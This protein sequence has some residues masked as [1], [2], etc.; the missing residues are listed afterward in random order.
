VASWVL[1]GGNRCTCGFS[2]AYDAVFSFEGCK[3]WVIDANAIGTG[4]RE[5][6]MAPNEWEKG[7]TYAEVLQELKLLWHVLVRFGDSAP[8]EDGR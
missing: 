1:Y 5:L 7:R 4:V 8:R 2:R 3:K 6:S